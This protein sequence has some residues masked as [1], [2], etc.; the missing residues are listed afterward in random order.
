MRTL[1]YFLSIK[2]YA[3]KT[4]DAGHNIK[5]DRTA[6]AETIL[7]RFEKRLYICRFAIEWLYGQAEGQAL[8]AEKQTT[9]TEKTD[10]ITFSVIELMQ[11]MAQGQQEPFQPGGND[12]D[13]GCRGGSAVSV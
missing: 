12:T 3:R 4:E 11:Q 9:P 5:V 10:S 6:D 1:L 7:R 8:V 13:R 2:G